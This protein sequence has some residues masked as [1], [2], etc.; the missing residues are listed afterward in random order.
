MTTIDLDG[1]SGYLVKAPKQRAG[2][3]LLPT[4][5]GVNRFMRDYAEALAA[6]GLTSLVWDPYP[7]DDLPGSYE[8]ALAKAGNLRDM[9]SLDGMSICVDYLLSEHRVDAVGAIGFCLGG[10]YVLLLGARESRL[11]AAVAVYP[12]IHSPK[13]ANQDE[14][15][16]VRAG[17]IACPVQ[18]LYPGK[19]RV[20]TNDIFYRLQETLERRPAPTSILLYPDADHGF[21]HTAGTRNEE[22][23]RQAR[24]QIATFLEACLAPAK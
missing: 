16:V 14:D 12:S 8:A 22:A 17:E 4:I 20:T 9:P 24:P 23:D 11:G 15:A 19:D 3:V 13:N 2:V 21:M 10:R 7:G 18:V 1:A 5:F 6:R